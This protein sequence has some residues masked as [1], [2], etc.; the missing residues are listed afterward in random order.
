MDPNKTLTNIRAILTEMDRTRTREE[1]T[2]LADELTW[3]VKD[4]DKWLTTGGFVPTAW[5]HEFTHSPTDEITTSER[6]TY[7]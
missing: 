7:G 3:M 2:S 6:T 1:F 4:L 5:S